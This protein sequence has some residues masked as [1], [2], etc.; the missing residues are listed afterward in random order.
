[1]AGIC[2]HFCHAYFHAK[3]VKLIRPKGTGGQYSQSPKSKRGGWAGLLALWP[4]ERVIAQSEKTTPLCRRGLNLQS[5]PVVALAASCSEEALPA[6]MASDRTVEKSPSFL[7]LPFLGC[8]LAPSFI[9]CFPAVPVTAEPA[10]CT[11]LPCPGP[12]WHLGMPRARRRGASL[13][14]L[15]WFFRPSLRACRGSVCRVVD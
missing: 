5:S 2:P 3:R 11:S 9:Q 14:S 15:R 1:M 4:G 10:A 8:S 13:L 7:L 6:C 12:C